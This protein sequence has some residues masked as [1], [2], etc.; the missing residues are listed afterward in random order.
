MKLFSRKP[1]PKISI[2]VISYN[3][4]RE[5]PKTLLTLRA[6]YQQ[7]IS[8]D[9]IEIIV[10]DNGSKAPPNIPSGFTNVKFVTCTQS[11]H[12]PAK[13]VNEGLALCSAGLIGLMV[14]G[15]RLVSPRLL[16]YALMANKL[17][18]NAVIATTAYHLGSE[19]QMQSTLEGYNQ[20]AEDALLDS[21]PWQENGYEL[22]NISVLAGSSCDGWF[23]PIA[24]SNALFFGRNIWDVLEGVDE[25][26]KT[27]GGGLVNLDLFVR[28]CELQETTLITLL[29]EGTFHQ[30]HG[31]IATNQHRED[32]SWDVFH[33]EYVTLRGKDFSKPVKKSLFFG[34]INS[35]HN[36]VLKYSTDRLL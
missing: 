34:G 20:K 16:S 19:V 33:A 5:L 10:V 4:Q 32:A 29:G 35:E 24:E 23:K 18:A 12:S 21:V 25:G 3:M 13:A 26:F 15:A 22:F 11:S 36:E 30:V 7:G 14:D 28:A 27:L 2:V 6:P 1:T 8:N 31:G 17:S 9:D